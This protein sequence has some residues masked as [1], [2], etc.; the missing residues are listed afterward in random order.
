MRLG[1]C[2]LLSFAT[3]NFFY[4]PSL[5][6]QSE[7]ADRIECQPQHDVDAGKSESQAR[8]NERQQQDRRRQRVRLKSKQTMKQVLIE[9]KRPT[10]MLSTCGHVSCFLELPPCVVQP[11][12]RFAVWSHLSSRFTDVEK[13][14]IRAHR[15]E[16]KRN[17]M[18]RRQAILLDARDMFVHP[19]CSQA[20]VS[21]APQ[22][23]KGKK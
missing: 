8:S 16:A 5:H 21:N 11:R 1:R 13:L 17:A 20:A 18:V 2:R 23:G 22:A 7:A 9:R 3:R 10:H 12:R 19:S 14:R 4:R 15:T 6:R